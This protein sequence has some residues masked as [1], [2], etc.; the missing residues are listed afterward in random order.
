VRWTERFGKLG[1]QESQ[2]SSLISQV[3]L[4][5]AE[6]LAAPAERLALLAQR[7]TT[8]SLCSSLSARL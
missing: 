2:L 1:L 4:V 6:R 5:L 7:L 3:M 8:S